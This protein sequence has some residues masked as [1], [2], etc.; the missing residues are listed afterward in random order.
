MLAMLM[1]KIHVNLKYEPIK[2][3]SKHV[4]FTL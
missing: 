3:K 4:N 1:G 2:T